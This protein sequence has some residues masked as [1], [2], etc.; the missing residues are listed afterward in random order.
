MTA[1]TMNSAPIFSQLAPVVRGVDKFFNLASRPVL[2][3]AKTE[4]NWPNIKKGSVRG[5]KTLARL[6]SWF[7]F[8]LAN[9]EFYSH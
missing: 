1:L 3:L 8:I 9:P 4:N 6:A 5:K 2:S 7:V